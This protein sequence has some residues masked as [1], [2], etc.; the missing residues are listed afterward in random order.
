M[1][2]TQGETPQHIWGN[3]AVWFTSVIPAPELFS[4]AGVHGE[5]YAPVGDAIEDTVPSPCQ[6]PTH[7]LQS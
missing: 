6:A 4:G 7:S 3:T 2:V 5:Y 1:A